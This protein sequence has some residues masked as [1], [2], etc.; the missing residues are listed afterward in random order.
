VP[1]I[2]QRINYNGFVNKIRRLQLSHLV[3]EA[4]ESLLNFSLMVEE[5]AM[6]NGTKGIRQSIDARFQAIGGWTKTTVGGIDWQKSGPTG[7]KLGVEVQVSGRSDMLAVD[8][9][10]LKEEINFGHIDAGVIIVPDDRLSKFLTDRTPNLATAIKHVEDR[11]RDMPIRI[12]AF[13][14][15]GVGPALVKMRTNRGRNSN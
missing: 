12:V 6:A 4:E 9:M 3:D 5:E 8:I 11:A 14:H 10:H 7:A 15:D 1:I 2:L 13:G